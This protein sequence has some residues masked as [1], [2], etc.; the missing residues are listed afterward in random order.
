[1]AD[2]PRRRTTPRPGRFAPKRFT[3]VTTENELRKLFKEK[4]ILE[5]VRS[6]EYSWRLLR[7]GHPSPPKANEKVCTKSQLIAYFNAGGNKV[8]EVHQ[9]LRD[10]GTIGASGEPDPKV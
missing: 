2:S 1:M 10:D 9:Y 6:G 7:D 4:R 5:K 3:Q 8:A